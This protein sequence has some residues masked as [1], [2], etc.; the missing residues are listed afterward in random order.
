VAAD[1]AA[2][3]TG[4]N[5]GLRDRADLLALHDDVPTAVGRRRGGCRFLG[6]TAAHH[7]DVAALL[8]ADLED[9]SPNL[10]VGYR[11]VGPARITD[12]LHQRLDLEIAPRRRR[13]RT[14][15]GRNRQPIILR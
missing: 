4:A 15:A 5:I 8:A 2:L 12:D 14:A 1:L 7:D 11:V 10:V 3:E 6:L 13:D 9:L